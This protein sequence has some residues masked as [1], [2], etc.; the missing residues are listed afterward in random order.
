MNKKIT[1]KKIRKLPSFETYQNN[2]YDSLFLDI[3]ETVIIDV[4]A[5]KFGKKKLHMVNAEAYALNPEIINKKL[6]L[7]DWHAKIESL[8]GF[9]LINIVMDK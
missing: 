6:I 4:S 1:N 5:Y 8:V 9:F 7:Y 2:I 3:K